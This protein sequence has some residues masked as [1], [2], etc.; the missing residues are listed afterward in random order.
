M[1]IKKSE[2][3]NDVDQITYFIENIK[4]VNFADTKIF[5][6]KI[7]LFQSYFTNLGVKIHTVI[8]NYK[9]EKKVMSID[10]EIEECIKLCF[11]I[12]E[13]INEFYLDFFSQHINLLKINLN[14]INEEKKLI[15]NNLLENF[16]SLN[17][18]SK[19]T[20]IMNL[21]NL[22]TS[23]KNSFLRNFSDSENSSCYL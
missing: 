6:E 20:F 14:D 13:L 15:Q 16:N 23:L 4:S 18:I 3:K 7:Y 10:P 5:N 2:F 12:I 19:S 17:Y 11:S 1:I 22:L 8:S 9:R 21:I